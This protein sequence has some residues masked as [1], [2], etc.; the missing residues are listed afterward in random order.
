MGDNGLLFVHAFK[1]FQNMRAAL[2]PLF[3]ATVTKAASG[4]G[5]FL[6]FLP[7]RITL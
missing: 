4:S 1:V 6:A 5:L 2:A 7:R 3:L